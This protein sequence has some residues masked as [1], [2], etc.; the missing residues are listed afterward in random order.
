MALTRN[1]TDSKKE[2]E[3]PKEE[4]ALT[5]ET[6]S[7]ALKG[8]SNKSATSFLNNADE[9]GFEG[10]DLN[11]SSFNSIVLDSGVFCNAETKEDLVVVD[12]D[13]T[14]YDFSKGFI[15]NL[16][17]T[18]TKSMINITEHGAGK[19]DEG[20]LHVQYAGD[21]VNHRGEKMDDI[22]EQA[23]EDG[24]LVKKSIYLEVVGAVLKEPEEGKPMDVDTILDVV[25]LSVPPMSKARISGA[26]TIY[27][28][29][30]RKNP[31]LSPSEAVLR[32]TVGKKRS[33]GNNKTFYPW[34]FK[35]IGKAVIED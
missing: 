27:N 35:C 8:I 16:I 11:K 30:H 6:N 17:S 28:T 20:E 33:G 3:T 12:D 1:D 21:D 14:E 19:D 2:T 10:L 25:S 13:G 31:I 24:C 7:K 34:N 32:C 22:L 4:Q 9:D 29:R 18:R 23:E 15:I 5:Q 26:I